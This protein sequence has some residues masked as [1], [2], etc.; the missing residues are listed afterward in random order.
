MCNRTTPLPSNKPLPTDKPPRPC[1][2]VCDRKTS[3]GLIQDGLFTNWKIGFDSDPQL[4][5]LKLPTKKQFYPTKIQ[6]FYV[7]FKPIKNNMAVLTW[8]HIQ[9]SKYFVQK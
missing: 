8:Y 9:Y 2:I 7:I 3:C 5:D 6:N 4:H 1:L